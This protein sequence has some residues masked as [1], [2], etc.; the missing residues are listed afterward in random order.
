M[1]VWLVRCLPF[2]FM[3]ENLE[4][5]WNLWYAAANVSYALAALGQLH[6]CSWVEERLEVFVSH[7]HVLNISVT[8]VLFWKRHRLV[9]FARNWVQL[10]NRET[11]FFTRQ[12]T[13]SCIRIFFFLP[14]NIFIRWRSKTN[15][16]RRTRRLL[17]YCFL[18]HYINQTITFLT[19]PKWQ[20]QQ[21][22]WQV[23]FQILS[24]LFLSSSNLIFVALKC[25]LSI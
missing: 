11:Q 8:R 7:E 25:S 21:F 19:N 1:N 13:L 23:Y 12:I 9:P 5:P 16:L 10:Y 14:D 20:L 6:L 15:S 2:E 22:S 24:V 17:F 4:L 18:L 3:K